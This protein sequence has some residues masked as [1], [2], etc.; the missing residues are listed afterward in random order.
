[1]HCSISNKRAH[2]AGGMYFRDTPSCLPSTNV[3]YKINKQL[4]RVMDT[5]AIHSHHRSNWF[6]Q[7]TWSC[8]CC[9]HF[10]RCLPLCAVRL[11]ARGHCDQ[12]SWGNG[13][14]LSSVPGEGQRDVTQRRSSIKYIPISS[15]IVTRSRTL[16][17][18]SS[19][20]GWQHRWHTK[21]TCIVVLDDLEPSIA[22]LQEGVKTNKE[23]N[24]LLLFLQIIPTHTIHGVVM[25]VK[26]RPTLKN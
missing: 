17:D 15:W 12:R 26:Q 4:L 23:Y 3:S 24:V 16:N 21:L 25:A 11:L 9:T 7:R 20:S 22:R 19:L 8:F 6:V 18:V 5:A 13:A 2:R 1:M 10:G 14:Q